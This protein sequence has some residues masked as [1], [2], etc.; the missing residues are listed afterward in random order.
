M[1]A[2]TAMRVASV[3]VVIAVS[4]C[5]KN[6]PLPDVKA[7]ADE[8]VLA[9]GKYLAESGMACVVCHSR[10][11]WT[12]LG[13][14]VVAGSEY[15]G[16]DDIGAT[17]G[18]PDGWHFGAANLTPLHLKSWSDGEIARA[19]VFGQSK[20]KH[21]LFPMMPYLVWRDAVSLEDVGAVVAFLRTLPPIDH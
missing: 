15:G 18:F 6:V 21:G 20:D 9:R 14:P 3:V 11:D 12:K 13:G 16:S 7:S 10:R 8:A 5:A 1:R 4:A 17:E 19:T 2:E